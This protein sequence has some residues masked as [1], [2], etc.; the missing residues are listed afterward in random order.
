L[1]AALPAPPSP[2]DCPKIRSRRVL[3]LEAG[4][5]RRAA[6]VPDNKSLEIATMQAGQSHNLK[7]VGSILSPI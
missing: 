4:L 6:N 1:A 7:V 5:D 2:P 3:L